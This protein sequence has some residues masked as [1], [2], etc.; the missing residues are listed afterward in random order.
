MKSPP[1]PPRGSERFVSFPSSFAWG[2]ATAAYQIEGAWLAGKKGL[3][4]WDAFTHTPGRIRGGE[5][6]DTATD[7]YRRYKADVKLMA[8][9]GMKYYRFSISWAR[10]MPAGT[11]AVSEEGVS[12]YSA[13]ID[14]LLRHGIPID[15]LSL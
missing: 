9:M 2:T 10:I 11:G 12:F 4:I 8:Q 7:H 14:E 13:L 6:G 1:T 3:T 15:L 5:T